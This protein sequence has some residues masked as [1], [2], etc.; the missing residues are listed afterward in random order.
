MKR[1]I[2]SACNKNNKPI[3]AATEQERIDLIRRVTN[4]ILND[5]YADDKLID[6]QDI[7]NDVKNHFLYAH[8][9][10]LD[11]GAMED[12]DDKGE[13]FEEAFDLIIDVVN[14][15]AEESNGRIIDVDA[16]GRWDEMTYYP[17]ED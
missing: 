16:E 2:H 14:E 10:V 3:K 4:D 15:I 6:I 8:D 13:A 1:Y 5:K 17:L 9:P 11:L 12:Y 7:L